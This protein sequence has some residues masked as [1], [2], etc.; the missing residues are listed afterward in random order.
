M[1]RF[2][3]GRPLWRGNAVTGDLQQV[4]VRPVVWRCVSANG[5]IVFEFGAIGMAGWCLVS[6]V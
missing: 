4:V 5:R 1:D 2:S 6:R 3:V